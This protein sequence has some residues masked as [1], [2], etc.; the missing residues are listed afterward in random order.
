MSIADRA[1]RKLAA[2]EELSTGEAAA[3][4]GVDKTTVLRMVKADPPQIRSRVK[5]G[6][7]RYLLLNPADVKAMRGESGQA[8]PSTA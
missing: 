3:R 1:E 4:L 7:G 8:D 6:V 5:P 2:G